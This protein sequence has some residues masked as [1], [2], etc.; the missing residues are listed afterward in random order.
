ME[1]DA[2]CLPAQFYL[3]LESHTTSKQLHTDTEPGRT[4][5]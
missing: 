3:S 5:F 2:M 1:I 4:D